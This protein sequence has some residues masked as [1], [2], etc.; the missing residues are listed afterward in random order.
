MT[1]KIIPSLA[2]VFKE[3]NTTLPW[4]TT[5]IITMTNSFIHYW[6]AYILG[7]IFVFYVFFRSISSLEGKKRASGIL[8]E[9]PLI[10]ALI[11][12]MEMARFARTL[13][14]LIKSGVPIL[15]ALESVDK[16]ISNVVFR[17]ILKDVAYNVERGATISHTLSKYKAFPI[18]V[19]Q[20]ISVGESSGKLEEMLNKLAAYY[21]TET[22]QQIKN[23][24]ALIEPIIFVIVGLGVAFMVFSIIV[25]IYNLSGAMQ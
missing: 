11:T 10:S 12:N 16:V 7:V 17:D 1:V 15:K 13:A 25:P 4:T 20:M 6:Y 3:S 24:S 21:E 22:D 5:L 2:E 19:T 9:I 14:M 8:L 18:T 23:I